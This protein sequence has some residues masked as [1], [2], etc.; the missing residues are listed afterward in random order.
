VKQL[1]ALGA[2]ESGVGTAL[3]AK[4]KGFE[5]LVSDAGKIK[6]KYENVLSHQ[7]IEFEENKH[8]KERI[9]ESN[10]IVKSPGIPDTAPL[11][12]ECRKK[13]IEVIG[14]IEFASRYFNGQLVGITGSNGKTT[15]TSLAYH[16]LSKGGLNP[17]LGGNIGESFARQVIDKTDGVAVLELS[18][19]QLDDINSFR[20][21]IAIILNITP[22]HL[23][24][25]DYKM[26][27]Y[28]ASKFRITKYQSEEDFLV[29]N[30]DDENITN[31]LKQF[32]IKAQLIPISIYKK[33]EYGAWIENNNLIININSELKMTIQKLALQGKHNIY[34]SMA[35][36]VAGRILELRK[37][38]IRESLSDFESLEHR[39]ETIVKV[40]GVNYIN[41]SKATNINS[42]WYALES[43]DTPIVLIMG[44]V[45]KGNDYGIIEDLVKDKVKGIICLGIDNNK[46]HEAF[47]GHVETM[48]DT[49][50]MHEAVRFAYKMSEKGDTVILSPACASF[51]L[52]E[53]Y[54]E[55]GRQF[56]TAVRGL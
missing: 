15:T 32:P 54:E 11:V 2:G 48:I 25:Y 53:N 37:E 49:Q 35:A 33:L 55:R 39:L 16:L 34:N 3:L 26:E 12:V 51:D 22:D 24:R 18:S 10:I 20:P 7:G 44:G 45:D 4:S 56:K 40:S 42:T 29:Y 5:V 9:L 28:I 47:E 8:S 36:G 19:F 17:M 50:S 14:E 43:I 52:F 41:D 27:N 1:V 21:N 30:A 38:V 6:K 23:D 46:I 31:G 13:G